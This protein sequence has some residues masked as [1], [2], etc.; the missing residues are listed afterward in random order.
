MKIS[1]QTEEINIEDI[2]V[3]IAVSCVYI[4]KNLSNSKIYVG[5]SIDAVHRVAGRYYSLRKGNHVIEEMQKDFNIGHEFEIRTL[6]LLDKVGTS[7]QIKALE[8]FFILQ[9]DSV[10]RGY[11][12]TYNYP[13]KEKAYEITQMNAEYIIQCF[14]KNNISFRLETIC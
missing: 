8:T 13:T 9:Y 12:R 10:E 7:R 2:I 1:N 14:R 6:C 4:I 11:N 5:Y 3:D